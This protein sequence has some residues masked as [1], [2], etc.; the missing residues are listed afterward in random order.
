MS[1]V[2]HAIVSGASSG[3]GAA[4]AQRLLRDGWAVTG[5]SRSPPAL[6][7]AHVR[8]DLAGS[9]VDPIEQDL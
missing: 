4:I 2:P 6:G 5:I 9:E 1:A 7:V 3:I 8:L